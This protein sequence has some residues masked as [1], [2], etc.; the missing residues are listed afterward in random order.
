MALN[1]NAEQKSILNIF[2]N[3]EYLIPNYQ[4]PYSW[5]EQN[6]QILWDDLFNVFEDSSMGNEK[7]DGYF[8]GNIVLARGNDNKGYCEVI[9]GQQRLITI[10]LLAKALSLYDDK[11]TA[12][13][14]ILWAK[15]RRRK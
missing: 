8:L 15:N 11:N 6:C 14:N 13:E 7:D 3:V 10:V 2:A 5:D 9:D 12:L 1:L 4:R